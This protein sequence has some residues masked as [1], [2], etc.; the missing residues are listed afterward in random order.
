MEQQEATNTYLEEVEI[1]KLREN[2]KLS[3]KERFLA[4]MKLIK[5]D[6][7]THPEKYPYRKPG[8]YLGGVRW[9]EGDEIITMEDGLPHIVRN[10]VPL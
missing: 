3:H 4:L 7:L 6:R 9:E 1:N 10:G 8:L 2:L 5:E